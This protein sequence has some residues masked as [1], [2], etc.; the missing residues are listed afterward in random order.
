MTSLKEQV[1]LQSSLIGNKEDKQ[2][3]K[4]IR[5]QKENKTN[6]PNDNVSHLSPR[7]IDS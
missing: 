2:A 7:S 6:N 5:D 1:T 4:K 3:S